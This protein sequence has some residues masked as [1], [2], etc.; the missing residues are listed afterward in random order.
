ML[1][2]TSKLKVKGVQKCRYIRIAEEPRQIRQSAGNGR[3]IWGRH[4]V[5]QLTV[6]GQEA[7]VPIEHIYCWR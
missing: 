7:F 4:I 2:S 1:W 3:I 5:R 6:H